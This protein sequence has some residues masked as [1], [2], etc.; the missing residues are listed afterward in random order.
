MA[1]IEEVI[2]SKDP[3]TIKKRRSNFQGMLTTIHK[4]LGRLLVKTAGK[5]DHVR[6]QRIPVLEQEAK[7]KKLQE[8]FEAL[9]QAYQEYRETGEDDTKEEALVEKEDEHYFGVTDKIYESLQFIA[10]YE[11]SF[12][13]YKSA[14]P[15]P[16]LAKREAEEKSALETRS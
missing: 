1:S 12:Q 7:L 6:I 10:D 2:S 8:G 3:E 11:E 13:I 9:H 16:E 4:N 15:D 14:K 5:F